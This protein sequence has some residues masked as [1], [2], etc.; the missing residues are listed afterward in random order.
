MR[1]TSLRLLRAAVA[2]VLL[3]I[4]LLS[5]PGMCGPNGNAKILVN[6]PRVDTNPCFH[7]TP[8]C[9]QMITSGSLYPPRLYYAFLMVTDGDNAT[10]IMSVQCGVGYDP[11]PGSG[12][13]VYSWILCADAQVPE[14]GANGPWPAPLSGNVIHWNGDTNCQQ[15]EPGGPGTGVIAKAG[16]FYVAAYTPDNLSI[17]VHPTD[18][19]AIVESCTAVVDTVAGGPVVRNPS[20]LGFARFS[21]GGTEPGY[22]PCGLG[23]PVRATTWGRIKATY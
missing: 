21:E 14:A 7:L 9:D 2:V 15:L 10:G 3:G 17:V 16:F 19:L 4:A 5:A 23:V 18:G 13:E 6:V 11:T 20:P 12:V 1:S 22:N 8:R